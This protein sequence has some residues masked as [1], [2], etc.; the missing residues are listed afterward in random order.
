[1]EFFKSVLNGIGSGAGVAWPLFGIVFTLFGGAV[2][3]LFSLTLGI[4]S[5][6]LFFAVGIPIFYFSYQ[7]MKNEE[8]RFQ[9]QLD[10]NQQKLL[11]DIQDYL[12]SIYRFAL[13]EKRKTDVHE[14]FARIL[15]MD[16]N[17]IAHVDAR[18]PLYLILSLLYE[19]YKLKQTIP[20]NKVILDHLV[21]NIS[22]SPTPLSQKMVPPF[23]TF[24]GTFGSITGCSAGVS[25]VL[26][27]M[28]LFSS[29]AAFPLLGWG[30]L[31]FA[32]VSG[33]LMA[34]ESMAK[35]NERFKK[36]ELNQ[37]IKNIHSQLSKATIERDLTARLYST[38]TSLKEQGE[39]KGVADLNQP[40]LAHSFFNRATEKKTKLTFSSFF[41]LKQSHS[42]NSQDDAHAFYSPFS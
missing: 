28:G 32:L 42:G 40:I 24:V 35:T 1:M 37:T 20:D 26:T 9:E 23:F 5:I 11:T 29:F 27:G 16:L 13:H 15:I 19:E 2:A 17:K 31:A 14:L 10:K 30:I 38:F 25:G 36:K 12:N 39:D 3:S 33:I 21:H 8:G 41:N 18:S 4:I 34:S 6:S 7:E 22:L